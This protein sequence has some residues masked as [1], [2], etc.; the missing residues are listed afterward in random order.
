[1]QLTRST[2][3]ALRVMLLVAVDGR[4]TTVAGLAADL[5]VPA[6][7]MAK[8]VQRLRALGLLAT[9][10]GRSG[11]VAL[12]PGALDATVGP[13]V[14]GL[15][16]DDE[17][18]ECDRS[19]CPLRPGCLLREALGRAQEAFYAELDGVALRDLVRPPASATL[20]SLTATRP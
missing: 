5:G 13:V 9:S 17:V 1:M 12:A 16:G 6:T 20:L 2:D 3:L 14:R 7:H 11:G 4:R 8:L 19:A 10:R 15:E 18:V